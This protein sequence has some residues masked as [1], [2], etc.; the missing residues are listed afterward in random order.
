MNLQNFISEIEKKDPDVY[1][2]LDTRRNA[3]KN[4]AKTS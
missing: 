3:M 1:D 2:R 4:F